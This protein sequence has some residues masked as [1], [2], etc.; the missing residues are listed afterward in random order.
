[1]HSWGEKDVDWEGINDA[2]EF[3]GMYFKK[4]RLPVLQVK[5]KFGTVRVYCHMGV[6]LFYFLW[7]PGDSFYR[8]TGWRGFLDYKVGY[9]VLRF[10]NWLC[11]YKWHTKVYREGYR[12]AV[13]KWPHLK[14][15]ILCAADWDEYLD[16]LGYEFKR[17]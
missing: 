4:R 10:L 3:L 17:T 12:L 1:M 6:T 2:A 8:W 5:E 16:G 11:I 7:H 13:E 9:H 15:E 14:E